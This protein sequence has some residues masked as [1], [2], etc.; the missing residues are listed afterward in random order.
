MQPSEEYIKRHLSDSISEVN[1]NVLWYLGTYLGDSAFVEL[2]SSSQLFNRE[3]KKISKDQLFWL[4][5]L[6][7]A[8]GVEIPERLTR[9]NDWDKIY[10]IASSK[11]PEKLFSPSSVNQTE[12]ALI[13]GLDPS[14]NDSE[15]LMLACGKEGNPDVVRLLLTPNKLYPML[16]NID[17]SSKKNRAVIEAS[18]WNH[19]DSLRLL[20]L[21]KRTNPSDNNNEAIVSATFNNGNDYPNCLK[22]VKLLL[23]D[24]RVNPSERENMAIINACKF[25]DAEM[26]K[27]LLE[28]PR[29]DPST[30]NNQAIVNACIAGCL[31]SLLIL[32]NDPRVNPAAQANICIKKVSFN[33]RTDLLRVLLNDER[34]DPTADKNRA[35]I[36]SIMFG[37]IGTVKMLLQDDR[38]DPSIPD[39]TALKTALDAKGLSGIG[40]REMFIDMLLEDDRVVELAKKNEDVLE[41]L[42]T[43]GYY[44]D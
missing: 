19:L 4:T 22:V 36:Y 30:K 32:I 16:D 37:R 31:E 11:T 9:R 1:E 44:L 10:K 5:R 39:N 43:F 33:G 24:K 20:L 8:F 12:I 41:K 21:D 29:V 38:V 27:L 25:P 3:M 34:T 23:K 13:I 15:I 40:T 28:D 2:S 26:F 17:P 18:R 14:V 6:E 35:L 7:N 42:Q